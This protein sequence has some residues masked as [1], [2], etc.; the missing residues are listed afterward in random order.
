MYIRV[1][2]D[3]PT[4]YPSWQKFAGLGNHP[5]ITSAD[6]GIPY[7][8]LWRFSVG[9]ALVR[10]G[11]GQIL[12]RAKAFPTENF[13]EYSLAKPLNLMLKLLNSL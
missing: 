10:V 1:P 11:R 2:L 12:D 6:L 3:L 13:L 4:D 7:Q 9:K 8:L 5:D